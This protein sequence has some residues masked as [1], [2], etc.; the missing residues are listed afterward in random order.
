M[1]L[2]VSVRLQ[3]KI[4]DDYMGLH[5]NPSL[6]EMAQDTGI[7]VSRVHRL[8]RGWAMRLDEYEVLRR[9]IRRRP[10]L[11]RMTARSC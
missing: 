5:G 2:H 9:R 4:L 8:L 11:T 6:R 1:L 7:D 10:G 3:R